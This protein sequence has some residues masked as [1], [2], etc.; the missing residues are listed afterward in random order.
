MPEVDLKTA[1]GP[2]KMQYFVATPTDSD[3]RDIDRSKPTILFIHSVFIGA[4]IFV[5]ASSPSRQWRSL[6]SP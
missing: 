5:G 3:A 6:M 4:E 2:V 1:A